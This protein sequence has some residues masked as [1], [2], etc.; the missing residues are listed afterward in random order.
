[1]HRPAHAEEDNA[2]SN[3]HGRVQKHEAAEAEP[4]DL[5]RQKPCDAHSEHGR[6]AER[7]CKTIELCLQLAQIASHA[8]DIRTVLAQRV[9]RRPQ[10]DRQLL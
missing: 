1:M 5:K 9:A 4:R 6:L 7:S 3:A 10:R 2:A 8:L